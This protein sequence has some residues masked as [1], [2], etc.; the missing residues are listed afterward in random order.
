MFCSVVALLVLFCSKPTNCFSAATTSL[1]QNRYLA[2]V[3]KFED[4]ME[5]TYHQQHL[6]LESIARSL[7]TI[8]AR[9]PNVPKDEN[10][11]ASNSHASVADDH[12]HDQITPIYNYRSPA[13][14]FRNNDAFISATRNSKIETRNRMPIFVPGIEMGQ[15][16]SLRV[17]YDEEEPLYL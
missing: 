10:S 16:G 15:D 8:A 2:E 6:E 13:S 7:A 11:N 3:A 9:E 12:D 14:A 1:S 4:L 17:I 5:S